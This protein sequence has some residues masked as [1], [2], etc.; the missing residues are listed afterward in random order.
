MKAYACDSCGCLEAAGKQGSWRELRI[1]LCNI[2]AERQLYKVMHL[3]P[4]C[5]MPD[6]TV[7]LTIAVLEKCRQY[8]KE[9]ENV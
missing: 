1:G 6:T 9:R 7:T 2:D 8:N 3:C 4:A 5:C